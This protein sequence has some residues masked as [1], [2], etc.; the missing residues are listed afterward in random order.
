KIK[1]VSYIHCE[2]MPMG[3]LK[4]GSLALITPMSKVIVILTQE[5]MVDKVESNIMEIMARG[6]QVILVTNKDIGVDVWKVIKIPNVEDIYA[7]IVSIRPM[8]QLAYLLAVKRGNDPDKPRN[9]AKSV[10]VE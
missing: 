3:E 6:G 10:T 1:E 2:A 4:H 5:K 8:Q 7:P 9:L